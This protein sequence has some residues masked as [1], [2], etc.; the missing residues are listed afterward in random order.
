MDVKLTIYN[1]EK[2]YFSRVVT[3]PCVIG[4]S[5]QS[6]VAVVHPLVSRRHC[7]IYEENGV[8]MTRDLGS[9]NG[10]FYRKTRIGRGVPVPYGDAF[11]IGKLYFRID[12]AAPPKKET[13]TP[14]SL[15]PKEVTLEHDSASHFIQEDD[16]QVI[17]LDDFMS[18][19]SSAH[20][21]VPTA[22]RANATPS[23][24]VPP[25]RIDDPRVQESQ[26]SKKDDDEEELFDLESYLNDD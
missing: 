23:N 13:E 1:S 5:K 19:S 7:E 14:R 8:V 15:K 18:K 20:D 3:L 25:P 10:T 17:D 16:S 26:E 12:E 4:R 11:N 9:L 22:N 2:E 24:V 21:A 6:D